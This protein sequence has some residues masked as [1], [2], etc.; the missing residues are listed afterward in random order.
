MKKILVFALLASLLIGARPAAAQDDQSFTISLSR[1]FGY[2]GFENDIE[3]LFSFHA[4]G[5]GNL[6]RVD[7]YIDE[8]I[9]ASD[10][11]APFSYQFSTKTYSPG[12][13]RLYALGLTTDEQQLR[14][15]EIVRVFLSADEARDKVVGLIFPMF[16][17][18]LLI[19]VLVTVIPL[20]LGRGKPQ[21][22]KY[23]ISGGA[24]CPKC[25]LP[26]PIHFFSFHAGANNFEHCPHCS[27]WVWVRKANKADLAAAEARWM[28]NDTIANSETKED[29]LRRQ[30]DESRYDN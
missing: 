2:G 10:E 15:N 6:T 5:P 20:A 18:V 16:A 1:D 13:H 29:R 30:I 9:V 12:Q 4:H 28:G 22:G 11:T 7:F 19:L 25:G 26:F 17:I 3:G 27:K 8:E 24:V 21:P 14:S 23:G